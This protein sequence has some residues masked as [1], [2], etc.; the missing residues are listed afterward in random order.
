MSTI[1]NSHPLI[2][3]ERD[4]AGFLAKLKETGRPVVLTIDGK[5][6]LIVQDADAYRRLLK[7]AERLET[8]QAVREGLAS[9]VRGE[10][11]PLDEVFDAI[12]EDLKALPG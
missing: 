2:E 5:A 4:V 12:E 10:G 3:F 11:R 9:M 1:G 8:I 6:E 7:A